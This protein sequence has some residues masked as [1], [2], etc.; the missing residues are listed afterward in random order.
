MPLLDVLRESALLFGANPTV[1]GRVPALAAVWV[2][3]EGFAGCAGGRTKQTGDVLGRR[4]VDAHGDDSR[5]T[6]GFTDTIR[7]K[8]R[9]G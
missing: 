4:A 9:R 3:R 1:R 2:D 6:R 8:A 5:R 7:E